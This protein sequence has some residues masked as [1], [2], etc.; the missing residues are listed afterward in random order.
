MAGNFVAV[1]IWLMHP[2][3]E[4]ACVW[5]KG[6]GCNPLT[7]ACVGFKSSFSHHSS[8]ALEAVMTL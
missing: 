7:S 5:S 3:W 2:I 6:T 4:N 1:S 8:A